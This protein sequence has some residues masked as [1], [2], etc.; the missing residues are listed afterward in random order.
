MNHTVDVFLMKA[1][2]G[3]GGMMDMPESR[4]TRLEVP[5]LGEGTNY[6]LLTDA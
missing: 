6:E 1:D 2:R 4:E 3:V 5:S